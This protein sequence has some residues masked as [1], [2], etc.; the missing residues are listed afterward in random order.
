MISCKQIA[1][2]FRMLPDPVWLKDP[3]GVYLAVNARYEELFGVEGSLLVGKTDYDFV[4]G[5]EAELH[6]THDLNAMTTG[7]PCRHEE[8]L[9]LA[10]GSEKRLFDIFRSPLYDDEGTLTGVMGAARDITLQHESE[11][12][13]LRRDAQNTLITDA[14]PSLIS[15]IDY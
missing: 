14:V 4:P 9:S 6:R 15:Y 13:L 8:W 5:S 2:L 10:T 3:H 7:S 11:E 12:E 1:A